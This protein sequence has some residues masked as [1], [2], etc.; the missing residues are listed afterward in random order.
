[1]ITPLLK[2]WGPELAVNQGIGSRLGYD[3]YQFHGVD[4]GLPKGDL[5]MLREDAQLF[6][7]H[8]DIFAKGANGESAVGFD[9]APPE[10]KLMPWKLLKFSDEKRYQLNN[11]LPIAFGTLLVACSFLLQ[12]RLIDREKGGGW[13][14]VPLRS[15]AG[16]NWVLV[17][18]TEGKD[19]GDSGL[20]KTR[21]LGVTMLVC[22]TLMLIIEFTLNKPRQRVEWI[23][24]MPIMMVV[25]A[26]MPLVWKVLW[27]LG[28]RKLNK[29][30]AKYGDDFQKRVFR[31]FIVGCVGLIVVTI[32]TIAYSA[33]GL[34]G[35]PLQLLRA[36]VQI[37]AGGFTLYLLF[38][39]LRNISKELRTINAD[40]TG[41]CEAGESLNRTQ[42]DIFDEFIPGLDD[43]AAQAALLILLPVPM[44]L[45][46]FQK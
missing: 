19:D 18:C 27:D 8:R 16:N 4:F 11:E 31:P 35:S 24:N 39:V 44:L 41:P 26:V 17:W 40:R 46:F 6:L 25:G 37:G 13:A 14:S 42:S 10:I 28:K 2:A 20:F 5:S 36:V 32:W 3:E 45:E 23:I 43:R 1:T 38:A 15:R 29:G 12:F 30:L 22:M 7:A 9:N 21:W 33:L 34:M